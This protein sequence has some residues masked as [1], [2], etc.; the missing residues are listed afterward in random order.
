MATIRRE[1]SFFL[2]NA[3]GE[4]GR[5]AALLKKDKINVEALTVQDASDYVMALFKAR[6]KTLKRIASTASYESMQRDSSEF[7]LVRMVVNETDKAIALLAANDYLFDVKTVLVVRMNNTPG[8]LADLSSQLGVEG[9]NINYIYGSVTDPGE[10]C[11]FILS[12]NNPDKAL[13]TLT[14]ST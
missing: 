3:P 9:I 1:L 6:G 10:Q 14:S 8:E 12:T 11:L 2:K 13:N 5:L 4:M 7:A